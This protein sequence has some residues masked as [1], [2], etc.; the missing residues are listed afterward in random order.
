MKKLF[1]LNYILMLK[2][3]YFYPYISIL[4]IKISKYSNLLAF[5]NRKIV[6][7]VKYYVWLIS[8]FS[9]EPGSKFEFEI[10][11]YCSKWWNAKSS[12]NKERVHSKLDYWNMYVFL[13]LWQVGSQSLQE[14][15]MLQLQKLM[16]IQPSID[17]SIHLLLFI[18]DYDLKQQKMHVW[19][20]GWLNLHE[21]L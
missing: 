14:V 1:K 8:V 16:Q 19:M 15:V 6:L 3:N 13:F 10:P 7:V 12:L 2:Y 11:H 9:E 20:K 4:L 18:Y 5:L 17:L 21:L